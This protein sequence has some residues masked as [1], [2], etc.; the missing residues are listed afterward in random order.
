M[1]KK[2]KADNEGVSTSIAGAAEEGVSTSIAGAAGAEDCW[3]PPLGASVRMHF[4]TKKGNKVY[5]GVVVQYCISESDDT[6][7]VKFQTDQD[8]P[9]K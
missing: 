7:V 4:A 5:D 1:G 6:I 3:M 8:F 2:K 9:G